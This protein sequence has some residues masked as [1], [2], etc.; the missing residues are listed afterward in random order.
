MKQILYWTDYFDKPDF[1][2]GFGQEPFIRAGCRY[3]NCYATRDRSLLNR[4]DALLFNAHDYNHNDL[5]PVRH[6]EQRY[7]FVNFEPLA[8]PTDES[9]FAE[10]RPHFFNW[11]MTVLY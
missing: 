11:T 5:P 1:E 10:S 2:F 3:T 6:K 7:V 4:S 9:I 8:S